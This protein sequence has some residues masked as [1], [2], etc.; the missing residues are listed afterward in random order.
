MKQK[1]IIGEAQK[2]FKEMITSIVGEIDQFQVI[3]TMENS[4]EIID[5]I[6]Q[7]QVQPSLAI[8]NVELLQGQGIQ[9]LTC[10]KEA[11]PTV[12]LVLLSEETEDT[13]IDSILATEANGYIQKNLGLEEF[14][15]VLQFITAGHFVAPASFTTY[16]SERLWPFLPMEQVLSSERLESRLQLD[17]PLSQRDIGI[18]R[19]IQRG[20][21]NKVIA[22]KLGVSEGTVKKSL[23]QIYKE[24]AVKNRVQLLK[25]LTE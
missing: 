10:L 3:G 8:I 4:Q 14:K 25:L 7:K 12:K 18:I 6:K 9:C 15:E 20:W 2:L 23:S 16:L 1:V 22:E 19:L 24:L 13:A 21:T 11:Y 17:N 5:F